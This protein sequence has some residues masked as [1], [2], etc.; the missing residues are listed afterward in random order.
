MQIFMA[1][2]SMSPTSTATTTTPWFYC[3]AYTTLAR[4]LWARRILG[5]PNVKRLTPQAQRDPAAI[6]VASGPS[7]GS[8]EHGPI[9]G[10]VIY[11]DGE[12]GNVFGLSVANASQIFYIGPLGPIRHANVA[13]TPKKLLEPAMRLA[14]LHAAN[15]ASGIPW[16]RGADWW[17]SLLLRR[18]QRSRGQQRQQFLAYASSHCVKV[19]ER[20]YAALV[21]LAARHGLPGPHA[22]GKCDG[23]RPGT[24]RHNHSGGYLR[25][26]VA[27]VDTFRRYKFVL[28]MENADVPY[29][30]TEKILTAFA[31]G[32]IPIYWGGGGVAHELFD[33]RTFIHV[34]PNAPEVAFGKMQHLLASPSAYDEATSLPIFRHP[35][36]HTIDRFFSLWRGFPLGGTG[37]LG[38]RVREKLSTFLQSTRI[39]S[40]G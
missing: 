38:D 15:I 31:A 39:E 40:R 12:A 3:G 6:I 11:V 37:A 20:V 35:V 19:R 28:C 9:A 27:N 7:C 24:R 30:V 36:N 33:A 23:W 1:S 25:E 32:A 10:R 29:Y 16:R 5:Q 8:A 22:L 2:R 18:Q 4:D 17:P 26:R 13:G 14:F 34:D 21:D